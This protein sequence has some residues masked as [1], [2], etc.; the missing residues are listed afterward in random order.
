[1]CTSK[2]AIT[3]QY[4]PVS[5]KWNRIKSLWNRLCHRRNVVLFLQM[6]LATCVCALSVYGALYMCTWLG[7]LIFHDGNIFEITITESPFL[8]A[9]M[10][11]W[12]WNMLHWRWDTPQATL[13]YKELAYAVICIYSCLL[14]LLVTIA[15]RCYVLGHTKF[16]ELIKANYQRK[17]KREK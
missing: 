4:V 15:W 17:E 7:H 10:L 3:Q 14:I 1:M 6:M 12:R 2:Y 11:R 16:V 9:L 5:T 13:Y 8:W